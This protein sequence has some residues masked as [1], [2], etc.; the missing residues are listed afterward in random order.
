MRVV[1]IGLI[2]ILICAVCNI[3]QIIRSSNGISFVDAGYR[4][5][6]FLG[7][8]VVGVHNKLY[9]LYFHKKIYK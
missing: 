8:F 1:H 2:V 9:S 5:S 3:F 4:S 7:N 6:C